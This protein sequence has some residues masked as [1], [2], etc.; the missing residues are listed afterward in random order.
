MIKIICL[1]L[2]TFSLKFEVVHYH[3]HMNDSTAMTPAKH[4]SGNHHDWNWYQKKKCWW[5]CGFEHCHSYGIAFDCKGEEENRKFE[6]CDKVCKD[7]V[8]GKNTS[9]SQTVTT[10][11]PHSTEVTATHHHP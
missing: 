5:H 7:K 10:H 11:G 8:E 9:I 6:N 1:F 2:I 4:Y 3:Y